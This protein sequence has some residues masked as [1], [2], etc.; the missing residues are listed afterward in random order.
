MLSVDIGYDKTI[1]KSGFMGWTI[2]YDIGNVVLSLCFSLVGLYRSFEYLLKSSKLKSDYV[3][4]LSENLIPER[5][6]R[7]TRPL[8]A[9]NGHAMQ[10]LMKEVER[11]SFLIILAVFFSH[12][13][14]FRWLFP[15]S[16]RLQGE[17]GLKYW[18]NSS[19]IGCK[20]TEEKSSKIKIQWVLQIRELQIRQLLPYLS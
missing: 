1:S 9:S 16:G 17:H 15:M 4:Q 11:V 8:L 13:F 5:W 18:E 3:S 10:M 14:H 19:T 12:T 2:S 20:I 7:R 6:N